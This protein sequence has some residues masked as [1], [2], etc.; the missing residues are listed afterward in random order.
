ML[1]ILHDIQC[2]L[3]DQ[4]EFEPHESIPK[5][6]S[7]NFGC[8]NTRWI[9]NYPA[10]RRTWCSIEHQLCK[11]S[12]QVE[13]VNQSD[14]KNVN[15]D[16]CIFNVYITRSKVLVEAHPFCIQCCNACGPPKNIT[17]AVS[18][19]MGHTEHSSTAKQYCHYS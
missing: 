3:V 16:P 15:T 1:C 2:R 17:R 9:R 13:V 7:R 11:S 10:T 6:R 12:T 4:A 5:S 8:N 18:L 14:R 19:C